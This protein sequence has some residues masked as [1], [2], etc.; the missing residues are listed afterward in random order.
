MR[1]IIS[2]LWVIVV[3]VAM[4]GVMAMPA[5]AFHN[6]LP[7]ISEECGKGKCPGLD[8]DKNYGASVNNKMGDDRND[9]CNKNGI[10]L[11]T[12]NN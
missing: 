4:M 10:C 8:V 2:V 12:H 6:T 7:P 11:G 5:L 1:R 9:A 3:M